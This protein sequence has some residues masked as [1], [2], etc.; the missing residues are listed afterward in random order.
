VDTDT[1]LREESPLLL[2]PTLACV[3]AFAGLTPADRQALWTQR[4]D[5]WISYHQKAGHK[6][7]HYHE[8]RWWV[9]NTIEGWQAQFPFW[10]RRT[11][12]RTIERSIEGGVTLTE[13]YN[14]RRYDRTL[15]YTI[16]YER[17]Q[18]LA[19]RWEG[20]TGRSSS[21]QNDEMEPATLSGSNS[22]EWRDRDRHSDELEI[23]KVAEPIP[24]IPIDSAEVERQR[25]WSLACKELEMQMTRATFAAWVR[26]LRLA[27]V[28]GQDGSRQ[29]VL[30]CSNEYVRDWCQHRLD[31]R[32][33]GALA[34]VLGVPPGALEVRYV[35]LPGASR[36][37]AP[38]TMAERL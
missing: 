36:Q 37:N 3:L 31:P 35:V 27:E 29:A 20:E 10:S 30:H 5:F 15:W 19:E 13:S 2:R 11:M 12:E 9:W 34:G 17:L 28:T 14:K 7:K 22:P 1:L 21:G 6:R 25:V 38:G 16:D 8:G 23:V 26:P 33:R 4:L 18:E 32:I 24:E